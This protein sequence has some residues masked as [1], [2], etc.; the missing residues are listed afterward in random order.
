MHNSEPNLTDLKFDL[1]QFNQF[2]SENQTSGQMVR[3]DVQ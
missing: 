2:N 3:K 1:I